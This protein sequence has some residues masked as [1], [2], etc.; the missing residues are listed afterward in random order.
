MP[1]VLQDGVSYGLSYG[2]I[3]IDRNPHLAEE[4]VQSGWITCFAVETNQAWTPVLSMA[5]E[6]IPAHMLKMQGSSVNR[7]NSFVFCCCFFAS[8]KDV[9]R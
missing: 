5:G 4:R 2:G 7:V 9:D 3:D 6:F 8:D 1:F